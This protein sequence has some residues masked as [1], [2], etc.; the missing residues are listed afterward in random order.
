[1]AILDMVEIAASAVDRNTALAAKTTRDLIML[2][3]SL[4]WS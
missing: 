1:M 3:L 4:R 2:R